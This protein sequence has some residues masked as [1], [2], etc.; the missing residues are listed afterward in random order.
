MLLLLLWEAMPSGMATEKRAPPRAVNKQVTTLGQSAYFFVGLG[1]GLGLRFVANVI[2]V[3]TPVMLRGMSAIAAPYMG[4]LPGR[5][6]LNCGETVKSSQ[7]AT[8]TC[9]ESTRG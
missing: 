1:F 8:V 4:W 5:I 3:R 9:P 7:R 6:C 2:F